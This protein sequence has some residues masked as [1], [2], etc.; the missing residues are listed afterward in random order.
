[1]PSS[2]WWAPGDVIS[3]HSGGWPSCCRAPGWAVMGG[4]RDLPD[5]S[6]PRDFGFLPGNDRSAGLRPDRHRRLP[7]FL[8][9]AAGRSS[10][11]GHR[12]PV[13]H[14]LGNAVD[15]DLPESAVFHRIY[16]Q[17]QHRRHR[18]GLMV[19]RLRRGPALEIPGWPWVPLVF[20][21]AVLGMTTLS[22]ARAPLPSLAGVA[23]LGLGWIL[24]RLGKKGRDR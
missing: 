12:V 3:G 24:W 14:R 11:L 16:A 5:C 2:C 18:C 21:A 10:T 6:C 23:V 22:V 1:M 9:G 15:G 20:V 17:S 13:G 19:E 7:T 8:D 4:G